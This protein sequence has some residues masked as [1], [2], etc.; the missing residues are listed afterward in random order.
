MGEAVYCFQA[1]DFLVKIPNTNH[2]ARTTAI[3][4]ANTISIA[5][6]ERGKRLA[7]GVPSVGD[8]DKHSERDRDQGGEQTELTEVVDDECLKI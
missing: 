2:G 7:S 4:C 1:P 6:L 3:I 8:Q 5:R